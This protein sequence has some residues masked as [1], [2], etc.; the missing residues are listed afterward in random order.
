MI[1]AADDELRL[2]AH[3]RAA[4]ALRTFCEAFIQALEKRLATNG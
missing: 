1:V 4:R 2:K 3:L